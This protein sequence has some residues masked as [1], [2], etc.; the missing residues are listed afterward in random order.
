MASFSNVDHSA[1]I[2]GNQVFGPYGNFGYHQG[3]LNTTKGF[4]G[5]YNDSLTG[6]DYYQ[7]R[8]YDQVAGVFLSADVKQ[9]NMQGM[10]PYAYVGGNPETKNDPTGQYFAPGGNGNGGAPSSCTSLHD[11]HSIVSPGG[12]A[13][14]VGTDTVGPAKNHSTGLN[15][16]GLD[17]TLQAIRFYYSY[18]RIATEMG[19]GNQV[20]AVS[21]ALTLLT[22]LNVPV[23]D[24]RGLVKAFTGLS[25]EYGGPIADRIPE[26]WINTGLRGWL[27]FCSFVNNLFYR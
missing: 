4:T 20:G 21:Y 10:N 14:L 13:T 6:L 12:E 9:G 16:S 27:C 24:D 2:S 8:Y 1:T 15:L 17:S 23:V 22:A 3:S 26:G 18:L 19:L 7:S 11:C 25:D 5:Q